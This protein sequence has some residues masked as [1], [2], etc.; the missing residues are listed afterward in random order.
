MRISRTGCWRPS[1]R[2][3]VPGSRR[4]DGPILG[5][6]S[7]SSIPTAQPAHRLAG[8]QGGLNL[9]SK[10]QAQASKKA[11]RSSGSADA[12]SGSADADSTA[13]LGTY[14]RIVAT[15]TSLFERK[16]FR[17]TSLADIAE[18]VG[19]RKASVYYHVRTKAELLEL[20]YESVSAELLEAPQQELDRSL[21]PCQQL[22]FLVAR[23]VAFHLRQGPFLRVFWRERNELP[24]E[25]YRLIRK[26]ERQYEELLDEIIGEGI[27]S[28]CLD[29][30]ADPELIRL[31]LLGTLT[32]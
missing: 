6:A 27:E 32:T 24:D 25:T 13:D 12:G 23:H 14:D 9:M 8:R 28:G 4:A 15:A 16:G 18:A 11:G 17:A 5:A 20:V 2:S 22:R 30:D 21:P 3:P 1:R 19:I 29:P 26:R 31:C 10:N 7:A